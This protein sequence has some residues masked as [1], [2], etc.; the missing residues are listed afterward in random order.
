MISITSAQLSAWLVAFI[1]PFTRVLGLIAS[2]PVTSGPQ[3][4]A[5]A[6]VALAVLISLVIAPTLPPLPDI[7]PASWAG[8]AALAQ[9]LAVGVALG[10]MMRLVFVAVEM[11]A[12]LIGLQM[13]LGFA[14]FYDVHLATTVPVLGRFF[15]LAATLTFLAIDGHLLLLAVLA[16]T[17]NTMPIGGGTSAGFWQT[18]A[19]SGGHFIYA[20]LSLALPVIAALLVTNLALGVLSRAAPQLNIF[21]VGFPVTLMLGFLAALTSIPYFLPIFEQLV[22]R[23]ADMLLQLR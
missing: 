3:F 23:S 1:W 14:Q 10:F 7:D 6:K 8:L 5:R 4:P 2:A 13:G 22:R 9:E 19:H 16:E 11:A 20:A 18:L 15:G 21:A 17:F 12:E